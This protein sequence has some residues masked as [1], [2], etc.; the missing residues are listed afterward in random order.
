MTS[1][2]TRVCSFTI[3]FSRSLSW[4]CRSIRIYRANLPIATCRISESTSIR[5][6]LQ[7]GFGNT[8]EHWKL[9]RN[10]QTSDSPFTLRS[11]RVSKLEGESPPRFPSAGFLIPNTDRLFYC[12]SWRPSPNRALHSGHEF[13]DNSQ[14]CEHRSALCLPVPFVDVK[15]LLCTKL[16]KKTQSSLRVEHERLGFCPAHCPA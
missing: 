15:I 4:W 13:L 6:H 3:F 14:D 5:S 9:L 10:L 16:A 2:C 1:I 12:I 8:D 7:A 11:I